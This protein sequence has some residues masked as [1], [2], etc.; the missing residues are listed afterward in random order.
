MLECPKP[1]HEKQ[2]LSNQI[3]KTN[4][5]WFES[6]VFYLLLPSFVCFNIDRPFLFY[7]EIYLITLT[8][9]VSTTNNLHGFF[10]I[11]DLDPCLEVTCHYHGLCKAFGPHDARCV[12]VDSCPSYHEPVCSSNGTTYDNECFY[13]QEMCL[14]QLNFTVQHPGSCEGEEY[15]F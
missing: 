8:F 11:P 13:K 1:L 9:I 12:C 2:S 10:F 7:F 6:K 15:L 4:R 14:H 5:W 3:S